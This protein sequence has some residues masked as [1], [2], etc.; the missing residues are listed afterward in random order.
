MATINDIAKK[1]NVS[2]STVSHVVNKTRF[3]SPELVERVERAIAE[4]DHPP[5]FVIKKTS[6]KV[7]LEVGKYILILLTDQGSN[8]Q[9]QVE[10]QVELHLKNTEYTPIA[11]KCID[12]VAAIEGFIKP[13]LESDSVSGVI[14]F[15]DDNNI[16]LRQILGK[17]KVPVVVLGHEVE[18][19][20]ADVISSDTAGGAF[21]A[22]KHLINKGHERIAF[23]GSGKERSSMR[24]DGYKKCLEEYGISYRENYVFSSLENERQVF[25]TLDQLLSGAEMPTAIFAAN[26][27][28]VVPLL[29]YVEAHNILCP[30]EI[31]IVSFNNFEWAPLHSPAITTIEQDVEE[32]GRLAVATLLQ[33]VQNQEYANLPVNKNIY[34]HHQLGTQIAVRSSTGGIGRG[35]FGERAAQAGEIILSESEVEALRQ[36][37]LTAAICFHYAGKAWMELHQRGIRD[38]F[39]N[40]GISLISVTD[41]HFDSE[42]QCRQLDSLQ[43]LKPDI[44]IAIPTDNQKTS[45]AFKRVVDSDSKLVLITNVPDGLTPDD[46]VTCVSVNERS[47]G[48]NMGHGLGEYMSKHNLKN[49]GMV[50]YDANFYATNQRD[51]AA[52]QVMSEE[53]PELHLCQ[54]LK[55]T[56]EEEVYKKTCEFVN[57]YPEVEAFYVSWDGPAMEVLAALSD[58][59]RSEVAIITSDLDSADALNMAKGGMI[60]MLSAQCP[61]EQGQAIAWAAGNAM[62]GKKTPSFIGVEPV[63]VTPDNLLKSWKRIFKENPSAELVQA[64]K[65]NPNYVTTEED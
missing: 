17:H 13:L 24:L 26:Y 64:F 50:I 18:G 33:R 28:V 63:S 43:I 46:Y 29:K 54:D 21:K 42:L 58:M 38:V 3:V 12:D 31:S 47:H 2:T 53:Y 52:K 36:K 44:V 7:P 37:K 59:G 6:K 51:N 16:L 1:A 61:Y 48:Q 56:N 15:P 32:T 10:R 62:L 14:V 27:A 8:F 5:N 40:L 4:L 20:L 55:F 65:E 35:P 11:M 30:D 45:A 34:Q 19:Y 39:D 9:R 23:L 25:D 57:R 22:V 41:A 60:K 49:Y